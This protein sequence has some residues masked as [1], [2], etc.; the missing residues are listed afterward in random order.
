MILASPQYDESKRLEALR[1]LNLLDTP[2]E[3]RFDRLVNLTRLVFKVPIGYISLVEANRQ[4][5]KSVQGLSV[6]ETPRDISFC[7][8]PILFMK[9]LIVPNASEDERFSNNPL[10]ANSPHVRFYA[11]VPII[12]DSGYPVATI[13][14]MDIEP[15]DLSADELEILSEISVLIK[16]E[17]EITE[18][19]SHTTS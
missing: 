2:P 13:C 1:K 18:I 17:F 4:W 6:K 15:R 3:D 12:L 10:V 16:R 9:P 11:G 8:Y 7:Q 14:I 5:F 19:L